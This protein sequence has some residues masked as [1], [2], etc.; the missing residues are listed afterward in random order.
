MKTAPGEG[1]RL[2][3]DAQHSWVFQSIADGQPMMYRAG[4]SGSIDISMMR[5]C[6]W[7]D[8][9][10]RTHPCCFSSRVSCSSIALTC[11]SPSRKAWIVRFACSTVVWSLPPK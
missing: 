8:P 2:V 10:G 4:P 9:R 7:T 1:D 5:P 3:I 6:L 11:P